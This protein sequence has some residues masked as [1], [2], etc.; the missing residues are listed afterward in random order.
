MTSKS[1]KYLLFTGN[2]GPSLAEGKV[3]AA[4]LLGF[5]SRLCDLGQVVYG[6]VPHTEG[7][8]KS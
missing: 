1:L 5:K 4:R 8:V 2:V 3:S 7:H 6:L